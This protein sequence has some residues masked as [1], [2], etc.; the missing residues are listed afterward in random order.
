MICALPFHFSAVFVTLRCGN[1][2]DGV[3][4]RDGPVRIRDVPPN[5]PCGAAVLEAAAQV[6]LPTVQFNRG[7][8]ILNGAGWFQINA[9]EDGTRMST[10]HA[11]LHPILG[12]R[13]NLE[14]RTGCLISEVVFEGA[15]AVGVRYQRP[16]LTGYDVVSATREVIVTL[17]ASM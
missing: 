17:S 14:V 6:G 13:P 1:D 4:G 5:D 16:D 2:A 3:H 12:S 15:A 11:Y 10:S 8:T 9:D 7:T